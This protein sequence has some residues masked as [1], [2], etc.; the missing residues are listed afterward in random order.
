[1]FSDYIHGCINV[2]CRLH[3]HHELLSRCI[4]THKHKINAF[5]CPRF[6]SGQCMRGT[7][8]RCPAAKSERDFSG[9]FNNPAAV[10]IV[11]S[12]RRNSKYEG[13]LRASISQS[14]LFQKT[15]ATFKHYLFTLLYNH[16]LLKC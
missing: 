13:S 8:T 7:K 15:A 12:Q 6:T 9:R 3:S 10:I 4:C 16:G 14:I 1:M 5:Q 2:P 11:W